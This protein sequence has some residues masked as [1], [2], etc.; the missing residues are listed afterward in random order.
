MR[1]WIAVGDSSIVQCTVFST[2]SPPVTRSFFVTRCSGEDHSLDEDCMIPSSSM[3]SISAQ[4]DESLWWQTLC[5][6]VY[7]WTSGN[8][9]ITDIMLDWGWHTIW[10]GNWV[11]IA[12]NSLDTVTGEMV[13]LREKAEEPR[14]W[15]PKF[16][17]GIHQPL[18]MHIHQKLIALKE[19]ST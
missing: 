4:A 10:S 11:I 6:R 12:S 8:Y 1:N 19:I 14:I 15:T 7:W 13:G 5:T 3:C 17:R 18:S 16:C 2:G 9:L